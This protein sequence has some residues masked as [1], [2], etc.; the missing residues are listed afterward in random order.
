MKDD[1]V[2]DVPLG[3]RSVLYAVPEMDAVRVRSDLELR[4]RGHGALTADL[5]VP[6]EVREGTARPAV[7]LVAGYPDAGFSKAVG[8]RFKDM[9]STGSWARLIA[10]SGMVSVAYTN[11]DPAADLCDLL[12]ALHRDADTLGIDPSRVGLWACSGSVP[13]ALW[14]L[15]QDDLP[16]VACAAL[17]YGYTLDSAGSTA[18]AEASRTWGFANPAA[19][20]TVAD[21]PIGTPLFLARAG[22]DQ[23]PGLNQALDRFI[24]EA[25]G[26]NLPVT[27]ANHADG[28]HAFDLFHDSRETRTIIRQVLAFLRSTLVA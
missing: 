15:M 2:P 25:L 26:R 28:P 24:T 16:P 10:A 22:R 11:R 13:L 6:P 5:Y 20:R 8:C 3:E 12:R 18:V 23:L 9:A 7:I 17:C 4:P 27:V 21:L 19:G 14:L 1:E